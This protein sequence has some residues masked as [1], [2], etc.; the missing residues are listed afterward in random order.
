MAS[1]PRT[2]SPPG[3][4]YGSVGT[5]AAT[6]AQITGCTWQLCLQGWHAWV[7]WLRLDNGSWLTW[8]VRD[9]CDH[10]EQYDGAVSTGEDP[11]D[12]GQP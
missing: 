11:T 9:G 8:C 3:T 12:G 4:T 5:S 7:P 10:S 2:A 6:Y 1:D